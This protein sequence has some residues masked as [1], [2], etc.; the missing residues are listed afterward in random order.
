MIEVEIT[1]PERKLFK[2]QCSSI[3]LPGLAGEF[4]VLEGHEPLLTSLKTGI[5]TLKEPKSID[6]ANDLGSSSVDHFR[7]M[8]AEGFAEVDQRHVTVLCEAAALPSEVDINQEKAFIEQLQDKLKHMSHQ[9]E[10]EFNVAKAEI[11]R[12]TAK[13]GIV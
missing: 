8:I 13:I 7:L 4:E 6:E 11:E 1:T 9:N 3:T 10:K 5:V 2:V 12:A